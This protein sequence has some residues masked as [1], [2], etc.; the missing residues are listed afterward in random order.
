MRFLLRRLTWSMPVLIVHLLDA[1]SVPSRTGR[2]VLLPRDSEVA[3]ARSAAPPSVS[4][5]ARILIFADTAF[6]VADS[7]TNGV[8]CVVN[9][10]WPNSVEPHCFDA[11]ASASILPMELR[12]T[13]LYHEGRSEAEVSRIIG[14]GLEKGVFRL[15]RRP[16]MSFMMSDAQRLVG[17]DGVPAGHWRPHIMV[18]YP[19]LTG[20][21]LG[22]ASTPDMAVGMVADEGGPFASIMII[23]PGFVTLRSL[24]AVRSAP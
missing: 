17:D 11:E 22:L 9:R 1:Q 5:L 19:Y 2:R 10:S 21:E 14:I 13:V 3:L 23:V 24:G 18:Y 12:R 15:P 6:V 20:R 7:G 4:A 16:A 8:T